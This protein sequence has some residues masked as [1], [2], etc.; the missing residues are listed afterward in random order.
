MT[1][2]LTRCDEL[3]FDN[4]DF[5]F[6]FAGVECFFDGEVVAEFESEDS[7]WIKKL[8]GTVYVGNSGDPRDECSG[9]WVAG[10]QLFDAMANVLKKSGYIEE[11]IGE[12]VRGYYGN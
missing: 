1:I 8:I 10:G 12:Y 9:T 5:D 4:F 7:W 11:K 3:E 6:K 2:E